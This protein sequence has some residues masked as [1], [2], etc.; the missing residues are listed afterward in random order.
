MNP[1]ISV[2]VVLHAIAPE[3]LDAVLTL[4]RLCFGQ[5]W[6]LD[7]YQR[8]LESPNSE[9]LGLSLGE[10]LVGL[11][12]YWAIVE[13]A[14]LT[15]LAIHPQYQNQG[16]GQFLLCALLE[17]AR[18]RGL[19]RATLEVKASNQ[20]ALGLYQKLGFLTAGRR[21]NYYQE[22][23]EDA[24]VLWLNGLQSTQFPEQLS[25]WQQ[26]AESK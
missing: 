9:L 6:S 16:L 17:S 26:Q 3:H 25:Q 22:T 18:Q 20:R 8:E 4:D 11:G 12:C 10:E 7:A 14:H 21:R 24:L 1:S 13:E 5:L 19:E 23:G 2:P 15:I